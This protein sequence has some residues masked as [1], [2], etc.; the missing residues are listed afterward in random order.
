VDLEGYESV[1]ERLNHSCDP[2]VWMSDEVTL[3]ARR[4]IAAGEELTVDYA[5]FELDESWSGP[6]RCQCGTPLCR[7]GFT[8][9]EWKDPVLQGR[10]VGHWHPVIEARIAG[11]SRGKT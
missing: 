4:D 3:I 2:N 1:E 8:G 11:R 6:W 7:G 9:R 10:Y 5:L